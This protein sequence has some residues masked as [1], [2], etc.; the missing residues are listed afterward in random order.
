MTTDFI[1]EVLGCAAISDTSLARHFADKHAHELRYV[2]A[3]GRWFRYNGQA[4]LDDKTL[5][6]VDLMRRVC[7]ARADDVLY[8]DSIKPAQRPKAIKDLL[9][10]RTINGAL[11]LARADRA[12]AATVEQWDANPMLLNTP[13]GEVDLRTGILY[14][15]KAESYCT[16][17]TACTPSSDACPTWQ[18]FLDRVAGGDAELIAYLQRVCGYALVGEVVEHALI[19]LFGLG[20]NG[21]STFVNTVSGILGSYAQVAPMDTFT[22]TAGNQHPTD[23]AMLRGS[24]L[25]T[26]TETEDGRRWAAAKI[27]VLTGGDTIA[28]RFMRQDFFEFKPQFTLIIS[29]N[30]KPGL[31]SVDEAMRRRMHLV[32]FTQT[33]PPEERDPNLPASLKAEWP[34]ILQWMIDGCLQWQQTGLNPPAIVSAA[35]EEYLTDEDTLG[36]W[37]D[38]ATDRQVDAFEQTTAL[39]D[40]YRAWAERT[41]EKL[42]GVKRFSQA[43]EDRGLVRSRKSTGK[44]FT[45]RRLKTL[46]ERPWNRSKQAPLEGIG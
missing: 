10:N 13:G 42:L 45:G 12:I 14:Q 23:L 27:K 4:W 6:P 38:E 36:Q 43:L 33:I 29:G 21:K 16:K 19:F 32:P 22:E 46:G 3:I 40:D 41:G 17:M 1:Q 18:R 39:H 26:A 35:T 20:A 9:S 2:N 25:V 37:L 7:E 8:D 15:A 28:A 34:A 30:H 5:E 31:R 11:S 44:G 24:R